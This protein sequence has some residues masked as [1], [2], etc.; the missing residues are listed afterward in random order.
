MPPLPQAATSSPPDR[1]PLQ[2]LPLSLSSPTS[3]LGVCWLSSW[4]ALSSPEKKKKVLI[5]QKH[6]SNAS[7][8]KKPSHISLMGLDS[9]PLSLLFKQLHSLWALHAELVDLRPRGYPW[10]LSPAPPTLLIAPRLGSRRTGCA[11]PQVAHSKCGPAPAEACYL[12][13]YL[14]S[15]CSVPDTSRGRPRGSIPVPTQH[16]QLTQSR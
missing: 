15:P 12:R 16:P 8:Y 9:R 7:S 5:P 6:N 1:H 11:G 14:L 4:N 3:S 2:P 10:G 13:P